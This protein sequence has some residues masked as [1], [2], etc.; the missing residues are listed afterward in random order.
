MTELDHP[1]C[2]VSLA[3]QC[4]HMRD[5][6][7]TAPIYLRML[8]IFPYHCETDACVSRFIFF[9]F[10]DGIGDYTLASFVL[11]KCFPTEPYPQSDFLRR[12]SLLHYDCYPC[13]FFFFFFFL[14]I[15]PPVVQA[16]CQTSGPPASTSQVMGLMMGTITPGLPQF[17]FLMV[18]LSRKTVAI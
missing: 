8:T 9:S 11:D 1:C 13:L 2:T 5:S 14:T 17:F 12:D 10:L 15:R 18:L 6:T 7:Q 16:G 3:H 4:R